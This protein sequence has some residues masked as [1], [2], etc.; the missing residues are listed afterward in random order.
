MARARREDRAKGPLP[1]REEEASER[2]ICQRRQ[3]VYG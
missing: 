3:A 1:Q 2:L